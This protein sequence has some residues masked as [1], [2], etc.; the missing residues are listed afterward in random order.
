M[1]LGVQAIPLTGVP[2]S[3]AE[4]DRR[5]A[6]V[7]TA[8][9]RAGLDALAV[10][11]HT[12]VRYLTGYDGSG[13]YFA[14]FPLIV[15]PDRA[16]TIVARA[17]DEDAVRAQSWVSEI[18]P[19]RQLTDQPKAWA[20][21]LRSLGLART[22]IGLELGCWNLSPHDVAALQAELPH[23]TIV[24]ATR[25]VAGVAAVKSDVE[26]DV[27]RRTMALTQLGIEAFYRGLREGATEADVAAEVERVIE[28]AG[29]ELDVS[30]LLFGRRTALPHG[31]PNVNR[32][33]RGEPA[34]TELSGLIHGYA[35]GLCR[36][37]VLGR[38]GPAE[39][40]HEVAEEA[41][42]AA[43]DAIRPGVTA[44]SVDADCRAVVE[45][46]GRSAA[47]RH[48]TGYQIG[49]GWFDRGNLSLEPAAPDVLAPGMTLHMPIILFEEGEFGVGVSETVVVTEEGCESLGSL[50]RAIYRVA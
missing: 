3:Q 40:L 22:R 12:H 8:M 9:A 11:A 1:A 5:M 27:M 26:L 13:G 36:T 29:G 10:T 2:F 6:G 16:P 4:Y 49:I 44:G 7:L 21:A 34:F 23:L 17:Y 45:R 39:A 42:Q 48:R 37:A 14:P 47:F 33:G 28:Q 30:A 19:Y 35:A 24:D 20:D 46:A 31:L 32:L 25:L 38:H 18:V 43:L 41:L 50:P 15:A